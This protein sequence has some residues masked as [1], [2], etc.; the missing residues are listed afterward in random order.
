MEESSAGYRRPDL[1]EARAPAEAMGA[2]VTKDRSK[3]RA[4]Q[5]VRQGRDQEPERDPEAVSEGWERLAR[6]WP[7]SLIAEGRG[8]RLARWWC[9]S[10]RASLERGEPPLASAPASDELLESLAAARRARRLERGLEGATTLLAAEEEGLSR[11]GATRPAGEGTR[12]S[13]LLVVSADGSMRFY[14][15]VRALRA[16][17]AARLEALRLDCDEERLGGA[18]YGGGRRARAVLIDHKEAVAGFLSMLESSLPA[19]QDPAA[20]PACSDDA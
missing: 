18:I 11:A 4:G 5:G 1:C 20:R 17:H 16:R 19:P 3:R 9:A 7:R 15:Q 14:Q 6:S 10:Q 2:S 8:E 12:I 13:R